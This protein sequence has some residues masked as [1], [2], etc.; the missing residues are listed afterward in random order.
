MVWMRVFVLLIYGSRALFSRF[1]P[2]RELRAIRISRITRSRR[3]TPARFKIHEIGSPIKFVGKFVAF[4]PSLS[5]CEGFQPALIQRPS[6]THQ[7]GRKWTR[8]NNFLTPTLLPPC[9]YNPT[10]PPRARQP[11]FYPVIAA[12]T[13]ILTPQRLT[14]LPNRFTSE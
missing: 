8:R 3:V 7:S 6:G 14:N 4:G 12:A 1:Q 2:V 5:F 13:E 9:S 11:R 10:P